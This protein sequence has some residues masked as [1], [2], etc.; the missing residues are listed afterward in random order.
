MLVGYMRVST[1][2]QNLGLQRDAQLSAGIEPERV[3]EDTYSDT[4][5]DSPGLG[6]ALEMLREGDTLVIWK[7]DGI[8]RP[9]STS[10]SWWTACCGE[11][12]ALERLIPRIRA[13]AVN[14]C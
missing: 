8:R 11:A 1:A 5:I 7:L 9:L 6:R 12:S 10:S 4:V 14:R 3:Y 13:R 2:E